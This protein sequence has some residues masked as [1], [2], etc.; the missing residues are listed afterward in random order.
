MEI[1]SIS[2]NFFKTLP[3][4][5]EK[6]CNNHCNHTNPFGVNFKGNMITADVFVKAKSGIIENVSEKVS[7]KSKMLTSTI[8]GSLNAFN[9]S[10][11]TRLNSIVSYGKRLGAEVSE[12]L[13][14][15]I[16]MPSINNIKNA[17]LDRISS[18]HYYSVPSLKK[19]GLSDLEDAFN[20]ILAVRG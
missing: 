15:E 3:S 7:N 16:S 5:I 20:N 4:K 13:N 18:M 11:S 6:D 19:M 10:M 9:Q 14:R 1:K 8:V 2:K 17:V 12:V